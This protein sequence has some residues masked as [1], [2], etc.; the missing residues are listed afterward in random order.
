M[1]VINFTI[2]VIPLIITI[3][4]YILVNIQRLYMRVNSQILTLR[5][6]GYTT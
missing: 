6:T 1:L 5:T 2:K 4:G 3:L